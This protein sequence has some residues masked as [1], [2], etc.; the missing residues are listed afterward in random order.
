MAA[1]YRMRDMSGVLRTNWDVCTVLEKRTFFGWKQLRQVYD[2][3]HRR[4]TEEIQARHIEQLTEYMKRDATGG[5]I[6]EF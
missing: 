6:A 2:D 4:P 5:I 1:R 3:R